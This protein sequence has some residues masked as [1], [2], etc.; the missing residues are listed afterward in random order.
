MLSHSVS[1]EYTWCLATARDVPDCRET[2]PWGLAVGDGYKLLRVYHTYP[3]AAS[4]LK[5]TPPPSKALLPLISEGVD[6]PKRHNIKAAVN[7]EVTHPLE[8][9]ELDSSC[10]QTVRSALSQ[11][12]LQE[13]T[14][15]RGRAP[16]HLQNTEEDQREYLRSVNARLLKV[17]PSLVREVAQQMD[18]ALMHAYACSVG[19]ENGHLVASFVVYFQPVAVRSPPQEEELDPAS[20]DLE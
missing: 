8:G 13:G 11:I 19:V 9:D 4:S 12:T 18:D 2:Y 5:P 6:Q 3:G 1:D 15:D 10:Q 7:F 20:S 16:L 17:A 14:G